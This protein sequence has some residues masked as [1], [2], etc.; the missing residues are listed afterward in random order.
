MSILFVTLLLALNGSI[1][2]NDDSEKFSQLSGP[3]LGQ[4]C[5]TEQAEVFLDGIVSTMNNAEMCAAFSKDG[6]EFYFNAQKDGNW[7]IFFTREVDGK[8]T[9]PKPMPFS[10]G[11]T[12]R[13]FTM[14]PD[15][16]RIY[17]GSNRPRAK[18]ET[19]Q[20][21]LDIFFTVRQ[22]DGT[23]GNPRNVGS[24]INTDFGE[25]YPSIAANGN[26]YFFSCRNEGVGGCEIYMS[27][28]T[29]AK[30]QPP[31]NLGLAIN[32]AQNDWDAYVAPDE[33]YLIFSSQNRRDTIG[34]Q[35]L[36]ISFRDKSG[37]WSRARNMGPAVNSTD[38]EICPSVS[39]DGKHMFFTS[40]RRGKADILWITTDII[41]K[42]RPFANEDYTKLSGPYLGQKPPGTE[43]QMFAPG[44]ISQSGSDGTIVFFDEGKKV[45]FKRWSPQR[46]FYFTA[47]EN[48]R[49]KTPVIA[50]FSM[51]E[52][53]GDFAMTPD[54]SRVYFAS[55]AGVPADTNVLEASNIWTSGLTTSGWSKPEILPEIIN[56]TYHESYPSVTND[57]TL[58]FFSRGPGGM[59]QS[60]IYRS[61]FAN[62][63]YREPENLG[64]LINTEHHEWDPYIAPDESYLIFC[65]TKPGGLG[66]DDFY[67]SFRK[68]DGSWTTPVNMGN[69]IN[70]PHSDNRPV[71]TADGTYFFYS[72]N[73]EFDESQ[74]RH[75]DES[76]R[77]KSGQR[78]VYWISAEV[79]ESFK[80]K[81]ID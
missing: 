25:N 76:L 73:K 2:T 5:P 47:L 66:E 15:G 60:D 78:N 74:F 16:M 51:T 32:S 57:G 34:K 56:T 55:R 75:I 23:W 44:I 6:R 21:S 79:L 9:E 72:S 27:A 62:G 7:T 22:P 3:Y 48:G 43:P 64:D 81:N 54:G 46:D 68:S 45:L 4:K 33:S 70:S 30:Y 77:P 36:Y 11:Y 10:A 1:A 13:D 63:T 26:L 24:P 53:D 67:I 80:P 65:S 37:R 69:K 38:D 31:V 42:L 50:S 41:E 52:F 12:D 35:D 17:F 18:G 39:P 29:D 14:S 49:W 71:V 59:G 58:Y 19:P 20:Q 8:W 40:R 28:L 61:R